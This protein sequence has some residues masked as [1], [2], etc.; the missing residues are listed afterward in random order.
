M[1]INAK[2]LSPCIGVCSTG[3]G[4][5]VCRGCKRFMH[6][7]IDWNSYTELQQRAIVTR[8]G[9]LAKQVAEPLVEIVDEAAFRQA[10]DY[11]KIRYDRS[12]GP[13]LWLNELLQIGAASLTS[14]EPLGCRVRPAY[15]A[16]SLSQ[17]KQQIEQD[18]FTLSEVHY[19]RYF[20]SHIPNTET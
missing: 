6:E 5:T 10:L 14:L 13:Y 15:R 9:S 1:T 2:P 7:V 19:Q 20:P 12:A 11:Q 16:W 8:L 4:D 3:I 17:I 18:F